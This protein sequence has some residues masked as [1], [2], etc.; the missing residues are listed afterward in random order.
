VLVTGGTIQAELPEVLYQGE[1]VTVVRIEWDEHDYPK[2]YC[3]RWQDGRQACVDVRGARMVS[4][5]RFG[6]PE[7]AVVIR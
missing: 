5:G 4:H 2:E 3:L 6:M 7:L 1:V